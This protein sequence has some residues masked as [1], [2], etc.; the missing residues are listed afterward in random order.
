MPGFTDRQYHTVGRKPITETGAALWQKAKNVAGTAGHYAFPAV[1]TALMAND[2]LSGQ[3]SVGEAVGEAAG[4]AP[5]YFGTRA[6]T[7]SLTSRVRLPYIGGA[8]N[9]IAPMAMSFIGAD[10]GA[11]WGGK[12]MPWRR[13][14]MSAARYLR[15]PGGSMMRPS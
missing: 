6:L 13:S 11:E 10:R 1:T 15:G 7:K 4:S 8:L 14:P 12:A 2:I 9:F 5:G 3:R